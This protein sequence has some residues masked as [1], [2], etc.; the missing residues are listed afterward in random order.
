MSTASSSN[1]PRR[2]VPGPKSLPV[3]GNLLAFQKDPIK[4]LQ[5]IHRQ[6]GD[7]V[8]F[9]FG[10]K[11][12]Y[13]INHPDLIRDVLV[14]NHKN[15]IKSGVLA[16][17][18]PI[19]G[20]GLVTCVDA[21]QHRS[22]RRRVQPALDRQRVPTY[23][24]AMGEL[25]DRAAGRWKDGNLV[26]MSQDMLALTLAI[27]ARTLFNIDLDSEAAEIEHALTTVLEHFNRSLFPYGALLARLPVPST[28]RFRAAAE[29]LDRLVY[30]MIEERRRAEQDRGDVLS[31][32]LVARDTEGDGTRMTDLQVRDEV[33]TLFTAGH[34]TIATALTWTWYLLSQHPE[35]EAEMHRELDHVLEGRIPTAEDL[36]NL[37]FTEMVF[38]ES[39][40]LYPPVWAM[41]RRIVEDYPM[42][43]YVLR[44][45]SSLGMCQ[46][47]MHRD[48]RFFDSPETFN[49]LNWT[50]EA[51]ERRRNHKYCYFPFGGG[52]RLCIG[53]SFAWQEGI[54]VMATL[55]QH[56]KARMA[57]GAR[58]AFQ[59]LITLRPKYGLPMILE[60]R[61]PKAALAP[62]SEVVRG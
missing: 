3:V 13:Q 56:W 46:Y 18:R 10:S 53:E 61:S 20:D 17:A 38:A 35:V 9:R 47:V 40:R 7:I 59:P 54:L 25:A 57:P 37:K 11:T 15:F 23:A 32:L 12:V 41:T 30:R 19:L 49:P 48:P 58:I 27:V 14:T 43:D 26:D 24:P 16:R 33:M 51:R 4:F 5:S 1:R 55:C 62:A 44:G 60:K 45:G 8:Q 36:P 34:E 29:F 21:E 6:Y 50:P 28:R 39:M 22:Q 31:I 52:S 42:G 2:R